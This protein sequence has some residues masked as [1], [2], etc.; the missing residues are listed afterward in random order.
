MMNVNEEIIILRTI[1]LILNENARKQH[2]L[3]C[4]GQQQFKNWKLYSVSKMFVDMQV[5]KG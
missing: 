2:E 5:K 3:G 4:G 1:F